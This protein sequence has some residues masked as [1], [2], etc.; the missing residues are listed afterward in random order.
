MGTDMRNSIPG[1]SKDI[2][3]LIHVIQTGPGSH[4][5]SYPTKLTAL[6][7]RGGGSGHEADLSLPS[8]AEINNGSGVQG[9]ER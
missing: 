4:P 2:F 3:S 1:R 7:P 5:S 6:S 8:T 9:V